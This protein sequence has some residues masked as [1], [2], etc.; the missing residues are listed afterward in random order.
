[1]GHGTLDCGGALPRL[2]PFIFACSTPK[3]EGGRRVSNVARSWCRVE[4]SSLQCRWLQ[5][6]LSTSSMRWYFCITTCA[7]VLIEAYSKSI[8]VVVDPVRGRQVVGTNGSPMSEREPCRA[9][10]VSHHVLLGRVLAVEPSVIRVVRE[11]RGG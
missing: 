11:M 9:P 4:I 1:M 2:L 6:G 3:A 10:H 7:N 8:G 5:L